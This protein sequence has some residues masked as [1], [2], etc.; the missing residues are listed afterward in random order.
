MSWKMKKEVNVESLIERF[1]DMKN[2]GTLLTSNSTQEDLFTQIVG[3]ICKEAMEDE[4]NM[5]KRNT[6][7]VPLEVII[8]IEHYL[9]ENNLGELVDVM[10]ASDH[11]NDHFLY[12]VIARKPNNNKLFHNGEW[13]YSCWTCWN[14]Q[15]KS[16]NYGHYNLKSEENARKICANHFHRISGSNVI[17]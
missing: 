8:D 4:T 6:S 5:I 14:D 17:D 1:R 10:R 9:K 12:H 3:T 2:R 11:P 15:F 13:N 16:L 7:P